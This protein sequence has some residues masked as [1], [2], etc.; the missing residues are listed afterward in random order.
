MK[1]SI[2]MLAFGFLVL[3]TSPNAWADTPNSDEVYFLGEITY[4]GS[5]CPQGSVGQALS[6]DRS[7]ITLFFDAYGVQ[8]G[9][10]TA[11]NDSKNCN[12]SLPLH[13]PAGWRYTLADVGYA[14]HLYLDTGV[15]AQL[16]AGYNFQGER[17][18]HVTSTWWGARDLLYDV[19]DRVAMSTVEWSPCGGGRNVNITSRI[20]VNNARNRFGYG[21]MENDTT[22]AHIVQS[23]GVRWERCQ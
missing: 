19:N 23:Y 22:E 1:K 7:I 10:S 12:M 3:A 4:G 2:P 5:G 13:I 8:V 21:Q 17:G 9:P 20:Q 18:P 16:T 6:E 14:G 15:Y 11:P